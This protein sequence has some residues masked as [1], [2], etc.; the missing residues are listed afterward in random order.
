MIESNSTTTWTS[1]TKQAQMN[2]SKHAQVHKARNLKIKRKTTY[3]SKDTS[4]TRPKKPSHRNDMKLKRDPRCFHQGAQRARSNSDRVCSGPDDSV[5]EEEAVELES[6][7]V[8]LPPSESI[9]FLQL[10]QIESK[11]SALT[12][13]E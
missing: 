8:S 12:S 6:S 13:F 2:M 11:S 5:D 3:I 9:F 4:P 7:G 1:V 10:L